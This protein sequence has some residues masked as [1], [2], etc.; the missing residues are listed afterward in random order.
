MPVAHVHCP[1][2]LRQDYWGWYASVL[3][4][5]LWACFSLLS[6]GA[7]TLIAVMLSMV[8]IL[9]HS[10]LSYFS[11]SLRSCPGGVGGLVLWTSLYINACWIPLPWLILKFI[12]S[13]PFPELLMRAFLPHFTLET[14][15]VFLQKLKT[16]FFFGF[17]FCGKWKWLCFE[18]NGNDL[19]GGV[20]C[21]AYWADLSGLR[22]DLYLTSCFSV[23]CLP[24][25]CWEPSCTFMF[26][27][28]LPQ[29]FE[30][31]LGP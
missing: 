21:R 25:V 16:S 3:S 22:E 10:F 26:I 11:V 27:W 30:W 19:G 9:G 18:T 14:A 15:M 2:S 5:I 7:L 13:F 29:L 20:E 17:V 12:L 23:F 31:F 6:W 1:P 28:C 8:L 24:Y 4:H